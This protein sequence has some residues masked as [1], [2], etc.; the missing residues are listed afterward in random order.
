VEKGE[1]TLDFLKKPAWGTRPEREKKRSRQT[2]K[3]RELE[4]NR[5]EL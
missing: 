4:D 3:R 2:L 5:R 1:E